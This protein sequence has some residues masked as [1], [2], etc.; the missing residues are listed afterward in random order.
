MRG[1]LRSKKL[2]NGK[3]SLYID[4]YPAVWNPQT[5]SYTRRE[6]LKL[7]LH[8]NP[9][10][11]LQEQENRLYTDIAEKIYLKRM[12][13]LMLDANGLFNHEVLEADFYIYAASFIHRKER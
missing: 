6:F 3:E 13:G 1:K 11:P 5:Q 9:T 8:A 7:Y 12:K 4:Y 10:T 2:K